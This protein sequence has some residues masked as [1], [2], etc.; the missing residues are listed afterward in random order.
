M[1]WLRGI[2]VGDYLGY[3]FYSRGLSLVHGLFQSLCH[4]LATGTV[5]DDLWNT[6]CWLSRQFYEWNAVP[7]IQN[8]LGHIGL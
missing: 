2:I 4:S 8:R 6:T 7:P 1:F 5:V 3:Q